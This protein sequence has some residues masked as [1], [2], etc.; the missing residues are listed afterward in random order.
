MALDVKFEVFS[1]NLFYITWNRCETGKDFFKEFDQNCLPDGDTWNRTYYLPLHCLSTLATH[2]YERHVIN[3]RNEF[4]S[5]VSDLST[6]IVN[7]CYREDLF[8]NFAFFDRIFATIQFVVS[9]GVFCMKRNIFKLET[10][11][12]CAHISWA[13]Y[14]DRFSEQFYEKGGWKQ[15]KLT[16]ASYILPCQLANDLYMRYFT[17]PW[18]FEFH[19]LVKEFLDYYIEFEPEIKYSFKESFLTLYEKFL[20]RKDLDNISD[21][22]GN[23]YIENF[24]CLGDLIIKLKCM[25]G[26]DQSHFPESAV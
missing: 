21:A 4:S 20:I 5:S 16:A 8:G 13:M 10:L 18:T 25:C 1:Y 22:C 26:F 2:I 14:F 23:E 11:L 12:R 15:L 6:Y 9:L 7:T 3:T 24:R 19:L 17:L